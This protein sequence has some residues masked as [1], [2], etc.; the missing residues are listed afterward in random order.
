MSLNVSP[1]NRS[2]LEAECSRVGASA[3]GIAPSAEVD[4]EARE[5]YL[6]WIAQ[7]RHGTMSYL[8]RYHDIR[9]N[10]EALLPQAQSVIVA[11]FNYFPA[12]TL[13]GDAPQFSYYAYGKDYHD[14]VRARLS[15]VTD[16]M[17][18]HWGGNHRICVDTAPLPEKYWAVKAGVGFTG[19]NSL[20]IVP[21]AGSFVFIGIILTTHRFS[22]DSP[23]EGH[24]ASCGGC[25]KACP[26]HAILPDG[27]IDATKCLSYLTIENRGDI[28]EGID[29]AGNVYGCDICQ[30]VCPHNR[31]CRPTAIKEF[32]PS[33]EFLSLDADK[34]AS[35]TPEQF[36]AIF[37]KSAVKRTK[38][39][40]L[41]RNIHR[42]LDTKNGE[43]V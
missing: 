23:S 42:L 39:S 7:G 37:R 6:K 14:V 28:P 40:G 31:K 21:G 19:K 13:P 35:M 38:H 4:S 26:N 17:T 15:E 5:S 32:M 18:R 36:S 22:Y 11:V 10:P 3:M 1:C 29:M 34:L 43:T 41:I 16:F 25:V 2:E 12:V 33:P 30:K 20:L 24:C 27:T 9:N 8:D